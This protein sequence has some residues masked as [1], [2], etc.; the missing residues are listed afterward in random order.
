MPP[1]CSKP[2]AST[3]R[4]SSRAPTMFSNAMYR[5]DSAISVS[6]SGANQSAVGARP[7]VDAMSVIECA[8]V[9]D[10][11]TAIS[12]RSRRNGITRHRRKST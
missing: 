9:N 1:R 2:N 4:R 6:M 7:R 10:V 3:Q 8:T 12:G 11:M 5:I